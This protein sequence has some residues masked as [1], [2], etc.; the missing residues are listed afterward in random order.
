MEDTRQSKAWFILNGKTLVI[1]EIRWLCWKIRGRNKVSSMYDNTIVWEKTKCTS[2]WNGASCKCDIMIM[3]EKARCVTNHAYVV[4][5]MKQPSG[6]DTQMIMYVG[7]YSNMA[8]YWGHLVDDHSSHWTPL[9]RG[10]WKCSPWS[11][12]ISCMY[13]FYYTHLFHETM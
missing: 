1:W 2:N 4:L 8:V 13:Y 10:R 6:I 5:R 12:L 3:W 11:P 7:H 9:A